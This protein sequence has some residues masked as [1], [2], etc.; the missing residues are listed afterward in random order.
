MSDWKCG[1]CGKIYNVNELLS[2]KKIK[3]VEEDTDPYHQ[4]G[5]TAVCDCGYRFHI[6][7]WRMNDTIKINVDGKE[8]ELMIS[9]I[10][11]ELNGKIFGE[12]D[13]Y[14]ETAILWLNEN[15][16]DLK[17]IQIIKRYDI[18][19]KAIVG[20]NK[21]LDLIKMRKYKVD[22]IDDENTIIFEEE[23]KLE[24]DKL[25]EDK[26]E[27][28]KLEE[29]KLEEDKLEEDKLEEDKLEEEAKLEKY[30]MLN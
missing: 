24:E 9:S 8:S 6:D 30:N 4:H 14:Y 18:K 15:G 28:D 16:K 5:Y 1:N 26:L 7:R 10:F 12:E 19:E 23:D 17:N 3:M 13:E 25:E 20:H 21:L 27:E 11:L 2:L 29:D 22:I